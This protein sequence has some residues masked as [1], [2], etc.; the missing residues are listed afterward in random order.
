MNNKNFR[1]LP[2]KAGNL[3]NCLSVEWSDRGYW[4][5][6]GDALNR[7]DGGWT[8]HYNHSQAKRQFN[9]P[10]RKNLLIWRSHL[11]GISSELDK[12]RI[13]ENERLEKAN[14]EYMEFIK[15]HPIDDTEER[16]NYALSDAERELARAE[17]KVEKLRALLKDFE[18]D[19]RN[20]QY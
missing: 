16:L 10:Y 4:I 13:E 19:R 7:R 17:D 11:K 3:I 2:N 9:D 5:T 6:K 12:I 15:K 18:E 1:K 20:E 8:L 14:D